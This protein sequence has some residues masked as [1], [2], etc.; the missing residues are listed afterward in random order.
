MRSTDQPLIVII[1]DH[2]L[3]NQALISLLGLVL[4]RPI[5]MQA[6]SLVEGIS[7]CHRLLPCMA[8]L[9]FDLPD[10]YGLDALKRFRSAV[11]D[12]GVLSISAE[13]TS[14]IVERILALGVKGHLSVRDTPAIFSAAISRV[15]SGEHYVSPR[16]SS[17]SEAQ[18]RLA[19]APVIPLMQPDQGQSLLE[20]LTPRQREI[21]T[22]VGQGYTNKEIGRL[23]GI[24][25]GTVK[26]YVAEMLS[27]FHVERRSALATRVLDNISPGGTAL[28]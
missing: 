22:L 28:G 19:P 25:Q 16:Y 2:P 5:V 14:V 15:L 26:N 21:V 20:G 12:V 4:D 6:A 23:L 27:R 1:N 10:A 17:A 13:D 24:A 11:P 3:M 9:A 8:I 18:I 7:L